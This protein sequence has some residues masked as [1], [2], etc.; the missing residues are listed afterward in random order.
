MDS[1]AFSISLPT[2]DRRHAMSVPVIC[3]HDKLSGV[4]AEHPGLRR[5]RHRRLLAYLQLQGLEGTFRSYVLTSSDPLFI[6]SIVPC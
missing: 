1:C 4:V 5:L 6:F 2:I 3:G